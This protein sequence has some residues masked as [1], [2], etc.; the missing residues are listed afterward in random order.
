M[1]EENRESTSGDRVA[2]LAA[3]VA[4]LTAIVRRQ[5][6]APAV[7]P[8]DPAPVPLPEN[9]E[10]PGNPDPKEKRASMAK[11]LKRNPMTFDGSGEPEVA[12]D[13]ILDMERIFRTMLCTE[14]QKVIWAADTLKGNAQRWWR[15]EL[16]QG[17][18]TT[19]DEFL[20]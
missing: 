4:E 1:A 14:Q 16:E 10:N 17:T 9:P 7:G 18:P 13:W 5:V 3:S 19:W 6:M 11:F 8:V 15:Q 12:D 20:I 2:Q